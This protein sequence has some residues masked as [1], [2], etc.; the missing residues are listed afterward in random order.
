MGPFT[1]LSA[2]PILPRGENLGP[3]A[4]ADVTISRI[5]AGHIGIGGAATALA[6]L[7]IATGLSLATF[8]LPTYA[9]SV[10]V[11]FA[12]LT[13]LLGVLCFLQAAKVGRRS[14]HERLRGLRDSGDRTFAIYDRDTGFCRYWYFK[15]RLQEEVVRSARSGE[16]FAVLL[17]EAARR[18][19]GPKSRQRL[20]STMASAFRRSDIVG[21]LR[22]LRFAV[23]LTGTEPDEARAAKR[24]VLDQ[25]PRGFVRIGL[26]CYPRDGREWREI[27]GSAGAPLADFYAPTGSDWNPQGLSPFD[28]P[29]DKEGVAQQ[30][31]VRAH[32]T[33]TADDRSAFAFGSEVGDLRLPNQSKR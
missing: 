14:Q 22:E 31:R 27:L 30:E 29:V 28:T 11:F 6:A 10:L 21:Q 3:K 13:G 15:L 20:L 16:T 2:V 12:A 26:A 9:S 33:L 8:I 25:L 1:T 17:V 32:P 24:R 5:A 18:R 4:P 7:T 19:N 23:L